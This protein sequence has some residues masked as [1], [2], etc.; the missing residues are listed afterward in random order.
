MNRTDLAITY[1]LDRSY[2]H[3]LRK[4]NKKKYD[5]IFSFDNDYRKSLD[6]YLEYIET[7]IFNMQDVLEN[8]DGKRKEYATLLYKLG[9]SKTKN[10]SEVYNNDMRI[11]YR[12]RMNKK[13]FLNISCGIIKKFEAIINEVKKEKIR[14]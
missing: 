1:E 13:D 4:S 11:A 3:M 9:L 7:L 12:V 14:C 6:K 8:Y 5:L 2:F 10:Y